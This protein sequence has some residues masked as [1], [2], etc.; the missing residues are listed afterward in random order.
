MNISVTDKTEK[1]KLGKY[2]E[3][4]GNFEKIENEDGEI[5]YS[6]DMFRTTDSTKT[7]DE[8]YQEEL[9]A[10]KVTYL[11]DTRY[12]EENYNTLLS[13]DS[14]KAT[15]YLNSISDTFN[16]PVKDILGKRAKTVEEL[17]TF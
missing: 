9:R 7:F 3:L 8:L 13:F 16:I 15:L 14:D 11:N 1:L 4:R 17:A 10:K 5:S 12:V 6:C 2:Y